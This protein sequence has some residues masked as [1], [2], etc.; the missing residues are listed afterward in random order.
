M[1]RAAGCACPP[2]GAGCCTVRL[3]IAW[4][5]LA[6]RTCTWA[7]PTDPPSVT[8]AETMPFMSEVDT[9]LLRTTDCATT[10][11]QV[12]ETPGSG[13]PAVSSTLAERGEGKSAPGSPA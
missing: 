10:G 3:K 12:T 4:A 13:C 9:I 1:R 5:P 8:L 6:V 2:V 11:C 7:V